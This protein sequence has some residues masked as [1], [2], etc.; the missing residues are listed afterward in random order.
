MNH[1]LSPLSVIHSLWLLLRAAD[2]PCGAGALSVIDPIVV[3]AGGGGA[4]EAAVSRPGTGPLGSALPGAALRLIGDHG[5][6]LVSLLYVGASMCALRVKSRRSARI[7]LA[8]LLIF[9]AV[10]PLELLGC[11]G[12]G[13]VVE[14]VTRGFAFWAVYT[15]SAGSVRRL[16]VPLAV[17]NS[18]VIS[19]WILA[20]ER[21]VALVFAL[22]YALVAVFVWC[23]ASRDARR[24]EHVDQERLFADDQHEHDDVESA[25]THRAVRRLPEEREVRPNGKA[26]RRSVIR[27]VQ[28]GDAAAGRPASY[29]GAVPPTRVL[30]ASH[31]AKRNTLHIVQQEARRQINS[32]RPSAEA[33]RK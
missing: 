25:R 33:T 26:M 4:A 23:A 24:R 21:L 5:P 9:V 8:L 30:R 14:S 12:S 27:R 22:I 10:P 16:G 6:R 20:S 28:V 7:I 1:F 3:V 13:C 17:G 11:V 2:A 15:S 31:G 19:V 29:V 18:F 32:Q